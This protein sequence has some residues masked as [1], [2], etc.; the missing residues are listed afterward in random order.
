MIQLTQERKKSFSSFTYK[1]AFKQ[2]GVLE[3]ERWNIEATPLPIS[4]F[5]RR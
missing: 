4:D 1:E 5:F 2:L 3:L